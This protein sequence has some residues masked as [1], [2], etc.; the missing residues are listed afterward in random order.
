ML[1]G[2]KNNLKMKYLLLNKNTALTLIEL[3]IATALVGI[4]MIG[5]VAVDYAIR[6]ARYDI[7]RKTSVSAQIATTMYSLTSDA[8]EA[9]GD[10]S[11][12]GI[13]YDD[14]GRIKNICFRTIYVIDDHSNDRW[15]CYSMPRGPAPGPEE[16][17]SRCANLVTHLAENPTQNPG[18]AGEGCA[19]AG[20]PIIHDL[21]ISSKDDFYDVVLDAEGSIDYIEFNLQTRDDPNIAQH[22]IKNPESNLISRISPMGESRR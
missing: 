10:V 20:A 13:T 1:L 17:I 19:E 12:P 16:V 18:F 6:S 11:D 9:I 8:M 5:A 2:F 21:M 15:T 4:V 14:W 7:G 3:I 22:V